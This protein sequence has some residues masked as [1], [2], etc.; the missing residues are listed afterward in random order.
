MSK[1]K[2]SQVGD[3]IKDKSFCYL[4]F[5]TSV[6]IITAL[7]IVNCKMTVF[8]ALYSPS[9]LW[10]QYNEMKVNASSDFIIETYDWQWHTS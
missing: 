1:F 2:P 4:R 3:S 6:K 8:G 7:E 10:T 9:F 5:V